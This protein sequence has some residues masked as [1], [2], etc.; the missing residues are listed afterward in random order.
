[1]LRRWRKEDICFFDL[2]NPDPEF[3]LPSV[4]ACGGWESYTGQIFYYSNEG[5][6]TYPLPIYDDV[7]T[8]MNTEE[9][10]SN[11]LNR[12]AR[13][14]FLSAGMLI[15]YVN[16]PES[17]D[18][19]SEIEKSFKRFQGD[20]AA[21]KIM[22]IPVKSKEETPEFKSF[23][24][25]NFDKEFDFSDQAVADKIGRAFNQPPI[26]RAQDV[27]ANFGA[28]LMKNAYNYY[29]SV[30]YNERL[31]IERT[32]SE[33]F[34]HWFESVPDNFEIAPLTY[35][36][37]LTLAEELGEKGMAQL[38]QI[39]EQPTLLAEQKKKML[40]TLFALEDETINN[41]IN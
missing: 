16:N 6:K 20:K 5:V 35:N 26:L 19:E 24:G 8:D 14:N 22:Y 10:I 33:L 11:V 31:V 15:D 37:S 1:M 28:D 27:G 30:T 3:I 2:F 39:V 32:F 25:E 38:L 18:Q 29:N 17:E 23:K 41:L 7:L 40:K 9:G 34:Q 4:E 13:N 36:A 21:C 12:N